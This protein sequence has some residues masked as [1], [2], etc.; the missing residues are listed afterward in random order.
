MSHGGDEDDIGIK[1][2]D[3]YPAD[4]FGFSE[5]HVPPRLAAIK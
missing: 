1:W 2:I 5:P 4:M 3:D